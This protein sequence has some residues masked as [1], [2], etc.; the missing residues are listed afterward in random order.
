MTRHCATL[1]L[2]SHLFTVRVWREELEEGHFEWRGKV[3]HAL[4]GETRYFRRW[5]DLIEFM[6]EK[7]EGTASPLEPD[8]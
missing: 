6:R 5:Q 8:S 7:G 4:S 1:S 2:P 3:Q